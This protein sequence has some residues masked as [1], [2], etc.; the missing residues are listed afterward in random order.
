MKYYCPCCGFQTLDSQ[1]SYDI[2]DICMW[3]DDSFQ[4]QNPFSHYWA[5]HISLSE[6]QEEILSKYPKD[7]KEF[8]T[9]KWII[10]PRNESVNFVIQKNIWSVNNNSKWETIKNY[11]EVFLES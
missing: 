10:I 8:I 2:C 1:N 7:Q 3:E 6:Y 11:I 4:K 5:N 9:D